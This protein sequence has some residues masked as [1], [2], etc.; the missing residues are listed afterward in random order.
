M[1]YLDHY[2]IDWSQVTTLDDL[3][4]LVT[5]MQISF[6]PDNPHLAEIQDLV[7][8]EPKGSPTWQKQK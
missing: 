7:R 8:R 5:A 4:R 3:K 2:V 6:E 1:Y